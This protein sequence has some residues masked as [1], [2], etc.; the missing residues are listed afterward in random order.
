M[1]LAFL[2]KKGLCGC[3]LKDGFLCLNTVVALFSLTYGRL[4]CR[5]FFFFPVIQI[6]AF[7]CELSFYAQYQ[8]P[9][10]ETAHT[11]GK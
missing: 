1:A 2:M 4:E 5:D 9:A 10:N 7:R 6:A 11:T 3:E 8:S